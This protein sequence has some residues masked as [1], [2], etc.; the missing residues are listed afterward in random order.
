MSRIVAIV[1][2][3]GEVRAVPILLRRVLEWIRPGVFIEVPMP[4]R[5]RRDR[6]LNRQEDFRKYLALAGVKAAG[7]G[8]VL[9]LLDA[10]DDCP[11]TLG[12]QLLARAV[13]A[14]RGS[15]VSVVLAKHEFE[16]WLIAAAESL[17]GRRGLA[18]DIEAMEDPEGRRDAKGWLS[19]RIHGG[20]YR[21]VTDQPA[22]TAVFDLEAAH[23]RSRSFRK[24]CKEV[25]RL[26]DVISREPRA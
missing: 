20:R 23:A 1:E 3:D 24:L 18:D 19:E 2:G 25:A 13:P 11:A 14:A 5:V 8:V 16:A 6:L 9:L 7:G 21:E 10:E 26:A 22:L 15:E 4:I 17:R 12:P